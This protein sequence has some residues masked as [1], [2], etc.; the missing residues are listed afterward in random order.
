M[1]ALNWDVSDCVL[2]IVGKLS[3]RIRMGALNWDASD[4]V[5]GVIGKLLT[6]IRM[7]AWAWFHSV[8]TCGAK[9]S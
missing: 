4:C 9:R 2:G 3:T 6:R 1:G 8:W 7:G 5:L